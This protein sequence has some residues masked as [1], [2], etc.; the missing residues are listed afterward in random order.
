MS[1]SR[2]W[3][4]FISAFLMPT[5]EIAEKKSIGEL[6]VNLAQVRFIWEEGNKIEK[7]HHKIICKSIGH[8]ID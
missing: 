2:H 1:E 8:S 3:I 7:C 5:V 4:L 6:Y